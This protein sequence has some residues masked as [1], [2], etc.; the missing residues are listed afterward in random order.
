MADQIRAPDMQYRDT[1]AAGPALGLDLGGGIDAIQMPSIGLANVPSSVF[2]NLPAHYVCCICLCPTTEW[3][4]TCGGNHSLCLNCANL[5]WLTEAAELHERKT[6]WQDDKDDF[7]NEVV[8]ENTG[9]PAEDPGPE[10]FLRCSECRLEL[11][12]L[13]EPELTADV[14]EELH[15]VKCDR[16]S[17]TERGHDLPEYPMPDGD[18]EWNINRD[19]I[20]FTEQ[21]TVVCTHESAGCGWSGMLTELKAHLQSTCEHAELNCPNRLCRPCPDPE[22]EGK[23]KPIPGTVVFSGMRWAVKHHCLKDCPGRKVGCE[24]GDCCNW[25]GP[26]CELEAHMQKPH[27]NS[28]RLYVRKTA[29]L[30]HGLDA[31]HQEVCKD[32]TDM[33]STMLRMSAAL[34]IGKGPDHQLV[35][36]KDHN[37]LKTKLNALDTA[38]SGV[39]GVAENVD[40]LLESLADGTIAGAGATAAGGDRSLQRVANG[41]DLTRENSTSRK[42]RRE[43]A[44]MGF[45][46]HAA[47]MYD[48]WYGVMY[49]GDEAP[50]PDWR[51]D[52]DEARGGQP[53]GRARNR[54]AGARAPAGRGPGLGGRGGGGAAR[55]RGRA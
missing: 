24:L 53:Q 15:H 21:Y 20:G 36:V 2:G 32:V 47:D 9:R 39:D 7:D 55:G 34:G 31:R 54:H 40:G 25:T 43:A 12:P 51:Q 5:H 35:K 28:F 10:P 23:M 44:F 45:D 11:N 37:E 41:A 19:K 50:N 46:E 26:M 38:I 33:K 17:A 49:N 42:R 29:Q 27:A 14:L 30:V 8:D 18:L 22:N 1:L 48:N 16:A 6:Q 3:V 13:R 52:I 4:Y